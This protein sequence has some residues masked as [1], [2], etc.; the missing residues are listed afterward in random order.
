MYIPYYVYFIPLMGNIMI[1]LGAK[2][3]SQLLNVNHTIQELNISYNDIGDH[4]IA[5]ISEALRCKQ[6]LTTLRVCECGL[7]VKGTIV[8]S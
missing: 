1:N 4:G 3:I 8:H 2:Y 6:S 5:I 7:S